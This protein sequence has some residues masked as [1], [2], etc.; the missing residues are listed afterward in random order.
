MKRQG[1]ITQKDILFLSISFFAIVVAWIAFSLYHSYVTTTISESLQM[2][3]I[4]IAPTFD[5]ATIDA[6]KSREQIKPLFELASEQQASSPALL[7][8]EEITPT[9]EPIEEPLEELDE[10]I[11]IEEVPDEEQ[12]L[13][14][15]EPTPA[16]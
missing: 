4:S 16:L 13:T 6:L 14:D 2:Q 12:T 5:T 7:E 8:Q 15:S 9:P 11:L 1:R 10:T 3:I